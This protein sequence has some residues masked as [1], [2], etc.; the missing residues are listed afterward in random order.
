VQVDFSK[1]TGVVVI[2]LDKEST[3]DPIEV[4]HDDN[5]IVLITVAGGKIVDVEVLLN[6]ETAERLAKI[7]KES[8]GNTLEQYRGEK[9]R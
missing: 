7:L 3:G 6:K 8:P 4:V 9:A 1:E 2:T 5:A